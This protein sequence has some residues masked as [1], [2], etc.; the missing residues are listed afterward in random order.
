[1]VRCTVKKNMFY[2]LRTS[3]TS[4]TF[5]SPIS[6]IM[7]TQLLKSP[8]V[9][10]RNPKIDIEMVPFTYFNYSSNLTTDFNSLQIHNLD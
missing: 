1:M 3:Q 9:P 10:E 7:P 5:L 6:I 8:W 4:R 2:R